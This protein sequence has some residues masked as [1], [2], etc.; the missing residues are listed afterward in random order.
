MRKM[1]AYLDLLGF[2]QA[3]RR[4]STS[5]LALL[6]G[7]NAI[8]SVMEHD[9]RVAEK[10]E[11]RDLVTAGSGAAQQWQRR[12]QGISTFLPASDSIFMASEN[13]DQLIYAVSHFLAE[14]LIFHAGLDFS[15]HPPILFRGGIGRVR[16]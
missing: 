9:Y 3:V 13:L 4:R 10:N 14:C 11:G 2:R 8:L 12:F 6:E 15:T 1:V 5:A 7:Y 16:L